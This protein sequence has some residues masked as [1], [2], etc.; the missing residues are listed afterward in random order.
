MKIEIYT[1]G[2]CSLN[3]VEDLTQD[4]K[5]GFG[6]C[7][8]CD[9]ELKYEYFDM[10]TNTT[11][12]RMELRAILHSLQFCL[13]TF[14]EDHE[15]VVYTDSAYI[16]NCFRQKWYKSW[17]NNGWKTSKRTAVKNKDLW[18][19]LLHLNNNWLM[20]DV[21]SIEKVA[22]HAN[23]KYNNQADKLANMWRKSNSENFNIDQE[24]PDRGFERL[25]SNQWLF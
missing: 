12:N 5:G 16:A 21:V 25:S 1:D 18:K 10:Y 17:L 13:K 3:N 23:V 11:N 14:G 2:S 20:K 19:E 9:G 6:Y 22:G 15:Y 7:V 24:S 8:I 4:A